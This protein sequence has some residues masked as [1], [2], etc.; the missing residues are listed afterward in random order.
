V[1]QFHDE[2]GAEGCEQAIT[3]EARS[4]D[5]GTSFAFKSY[6][7]SADDYLFYN[8]TSKK[9]STNNVWFGY[10][11]DAP[12]WP[13][14]VKAESAK[15]SDLAKKVA[16]TPG[17]IGYANTADAITSG[18]FSNAAT[19]TEFETSKKHQIVYA[20]LQD[21]ESVVTKAEAESVSPP[22]TTYADPVVEGTKIGNCPTDKALGTAKKTPYSYTDSWSGVSTSDPNVG[23]EDTSGV[24][25][26]I[27]AL[28]YDLVW[29]HYNVPNL[30]KE[31]PAG[32]EV[33]ASVKDLMSYIT[34][35]GQTEVE[36]NF[37][38][39]VPKTSEW[40]DHIA[41]AIEPITG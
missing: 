28:T 38:T 31:E 34:T 35:T 10:R 19:A 15:G 5:S 27:C 1:G 20:L 36:N 37:Y 16:K 40:A 33:A 29:K 26:P 39:G 6:L 24:Y 30:F 17:S 9:Y 25:Y 4:T 12:S 41:L 11:S 13:V 32:A 2:G 22:P 7:Y 14:A 8:T 3:L 18:T 23:T 21:N